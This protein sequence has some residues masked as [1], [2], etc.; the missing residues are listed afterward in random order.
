M[1]K[2]LPQLINTLAREAGWSKALSL[3]VN[4]R[5]LKKERANLL[6]HVRAV[7]K[8]GDLALIVATEKAIV[9]GDL[10]HYANSKGMVSS[11]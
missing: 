1:N 4:A 2:S 6:D 10:E 11:L 3:S 9:N 8:S 5:N 7:G